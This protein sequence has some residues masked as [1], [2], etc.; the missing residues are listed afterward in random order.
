MC[1]F[2]QSGRNIKKEA[3]MSCGTEKY[4]LPLNLLQLQ[5]ASPF[6]LRKCSLTFAVS[7]TESQFPP[8]S[9]YLPLPILA[10]ISSGVS[11]GP[12]AKGVNLF[13]KRKNHTVS[14][15]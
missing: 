11:S 8:V 5:T 10:R 1:Y 6:D 3:F 2:M 4:L 15:S 14:D 13:K 9:A 12:F 7:D